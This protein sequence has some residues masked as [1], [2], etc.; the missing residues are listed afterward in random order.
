MVADIALRK[1][2]LAEFRQFDFDDNDPFHYELLDGE[3]VQK[4]SPSPYHQRTSRQLIV[5]IDAHIRQNNLGEVFYSPIDVVLDDYNVPQPAVVFLTTEQAPLVTHDGIMGVPTMV[6]E[7][8]SPSSVI[9]DRRQKYG[10]YERFGVAEYWLVD[11]AHAEIEVYTLQNGQYSLHSA[12]SA[13]EGTLQSVVLPALVLDLT[14]L[15]G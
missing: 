15:F 11:V 5:A 14:V 9:R 13:L 8:I 1:L 3:V 2:T 4:S 7:I 6:A 12:A 10:I